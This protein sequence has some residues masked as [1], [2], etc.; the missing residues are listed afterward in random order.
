MKKGKKY[1]EAASKVEKAKNYSKEEAIKL[2]KETSICKFDASVEVAIRL[3]LDTKKADQQLRGALV[4]PNG[5]GKTKRVLVIAKGEQAKAALAAGADFVGDMDMIEKIEKIVEKQVDAIKNI[6]FDKITVWDGGTGSSNG[7]TT[8]NFMKD[9]I[10]ALP[11]MHDLAGQAGIELPQILGKV[12]SGVEE[13]KVVSP[14]TEP[15]K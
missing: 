11:A 9:L 3:N 6:K 15:K 5:T 14:K 13:A 1:I 2:V 12:D 10:K 8:A 7:S 4:L